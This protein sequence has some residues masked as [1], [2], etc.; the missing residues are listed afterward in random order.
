MAKARVAPA[1][2]GRRTDLLAAD[3][4]LDWNLARTERRERA[5]EIPAAAERAASGA[6]QQLNPVYT[7]SLTQDWTGLDWTTRKRWARCCTSNTSQL[8]S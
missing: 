3:S 8:K 1:R 6:N 2:T 4:I 5:R 7:H